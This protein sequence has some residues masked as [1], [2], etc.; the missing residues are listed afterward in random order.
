[1]NKNIMKVAGFGDLLK[2][3][4][5]GICPFCHRVVDDNEFRDR[6]SRR[7]F[8]ISGLCQACQ[9]EMFGK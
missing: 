6:I 8:E 2:L 9:D 3:V 7:E 5:Q 4:E 1:M